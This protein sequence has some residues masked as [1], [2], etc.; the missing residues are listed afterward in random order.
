MSYTGPNTGQLGPLDIQALQAMYG[1]DVR[2][3]M[4]ISE[5]EMTRRPATEIMAQLRDFDGN[6]LGAEADWRLIGVADSQLDGDDEFIWVNDTL[7]RWATLGPDADGLIDFGNH[8][9]G[10]DTRVVGIY[11]DPLVE[12]GL[13]ERGS[14]TDSAVRLQR[15]LE[16]GNIR[17]VGSGDF[18]GDGFQNLYLKTADGAAYLN[19]LMHADGNVRYANYQNEAQMRAFLDA[20]GWD[21]GVY[22]DWLVA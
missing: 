20:N 12:Q 6:L 19:A 13:V 9:E 2:P 3:N 1:S 15:D 7:G 10:G 18:D 22:E 5:F 14:D 16:A 17:H 11:L 4:V 21:A 8:G